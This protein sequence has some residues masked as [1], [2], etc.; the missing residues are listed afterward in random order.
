[1]KSTYE[2]LIASVPADLE[3]IEEGWICRVNCVFRPGGSEG[4]VRVY[5]GEGIKQW[6]KR[7][8]VIGVRKCRRVEE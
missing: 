5:L 7:D 2:C 6:G 3:K 4:E 1:M 8:K